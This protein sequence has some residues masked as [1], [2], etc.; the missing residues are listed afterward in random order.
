M[1]ISTTQV[2][3]GYDEWKFCLFSATGR[4]L[5]Y[6]KSK[7]GQTW[8][9]FLLWTRY[10]REKEAP[11][12]LSLCFGCP[13]ELL[14]DWWEEGVEELNLVR[15]HPK[16]FLF[17]PHSFFWGNEGKKEMFNPL[18]RNLRR[19]TYWHFE[20]KSESKQFQ[21]YNLEALRL[22]TPGCSCVCCVYLGQGPIRF[23]FFTGCYVSLVCIAHSGERNSVMLELATYFYRLIRF[24]FSSRVPKNIFDVSTGR[25]G[26]S[27]T[28]WGR[29]RP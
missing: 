1:E 13:R 3:P 7:A 22:V 20:K 21:L 14:D 16:V 11:P 15:S 17:A 19:M 6:R 9:A 23:A 29:K 25:R 28:W 18:T 24:V 4:S 10:S 2:G 27:F 26:R 12:P 8:S 5:G